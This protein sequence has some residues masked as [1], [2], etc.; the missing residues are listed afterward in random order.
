MQRYYDIVEREFP[1][2]KHLGVY[3]T[4]EGDSPTDDHYLPI[5]Y[6]AVCEII[7]GI[8]EG[9]GTSLGPDVLTLMKHYTT[10]LRRHIVSGSE[11]EQ[12]CH[13]IYKKHQ[14]ALD[15]IYEYRP[16]L[17]S[18]I[19]DFM[20]QMISENR[21]LHLD[22][23]S[24]SYIR[25]FPNAWSKYSVL[26]QGEGWTSSNQILIFEVQNHPNSLRLSLIIGPGEKEIREK[27]YAMVK[28]FPRLFKPSRRQLTSMYLSVYRI[29]LLIKKDYSDIVSFDAIEHKIINK[30]QH[31]SDQK[32][33]EILAIIDNQDWI[34]EEI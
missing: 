3:L 31:F 11:L 27:L 17:Q 23:S 10:M 34:W 33:P 18:E 22:S 25:F 13:R 20:T 19:Y 7:E 9:R 30:W 24:K 1:T 26:H 12:L 16:D 5:S 8:I 2:W 32:L 29:S 4:P 21:N 14:K 6:Q 28:S 15:L